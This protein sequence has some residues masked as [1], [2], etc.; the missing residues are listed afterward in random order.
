MVIDAEGFHNVSIYALRLFAAREKLCESF[1]RIIGHS[2]LSRTPLASVSL[3]SL[4]SDRSLFKFHSSIFC[5]HL[6][7]HF[8]ARTS[9]IQPRPD[10]HQIQREE[11]IMSGTPERLEAIAAVTKYQPPSSP[12][13]FVETPSSELFGSN[14]FSVKV[15]KSRLPKEIFKRLLETKQN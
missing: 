12:L 15:M 11:V 14:V 8:R 7:P 5:L 6:S 4:T 3:L 2:P 10:Q 9:P 13:N 1:L